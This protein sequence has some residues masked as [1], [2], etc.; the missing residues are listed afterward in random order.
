ME[1]RGTV[2]VKEER[3]VVLVMEERGMAMA[4]EARGTVMVKEERGV[5]MVKEE[6]GTALV[7]VERGT[8]LVMEARTRTSG[9]R[10]E[11]N[12]LYLLEDSAQ[13]RDRCLSTSSHGSHDIDHIERF[14]TLEERVRLSHIPR[15]SC[16]IN[17]AE[18][19]NRALAQIQ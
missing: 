14:P 13:D 3:G 11:G 7:M 6:R 1:A 17:T 5:V 16:F 19:L 2:M 18:G 10:S 8:V 12:L 9:R 4:M 15:A